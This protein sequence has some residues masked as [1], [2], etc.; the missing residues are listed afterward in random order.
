MFGECRKTFFIVLPYYK[1]DENTIKINNRLVYLHSLSG[2][3]EFMRV[4]ELEH[5]FFRGTK[6]V[7]LKL[8]VMVERKIYGQLPIR[9][10]VKMC[11]FYASRLIFFAALRRTVNLSCRHKIKN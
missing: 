3:I 11:Q 4:K 10:T 6:D 2:L 1:N 9:P 5:K 8:C 7:I